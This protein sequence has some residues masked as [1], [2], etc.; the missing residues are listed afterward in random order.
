MPGSVNELQ[1]ELADPRRV[2]GLNFDE[3]GIAEAGDAFYAIGLVL[4][5]VDLRLD[6]RHQLGGALDILAHQMAAQM[7]LM[8]VGQKDLL[9]SVVLAFAIPDD[10]IDF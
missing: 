4:V 10:A 8:I 7:I 6:A 9:D 1:I 3:V 5:D 2:A